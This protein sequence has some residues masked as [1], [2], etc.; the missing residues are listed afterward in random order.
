MCMLQD[1]LTAI[2]KSIYPHTPDVEQD[3][4]L[5]LTVFRSL[6]KLVQQEDAR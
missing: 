1:W 6:A 2:N 3:Y 5:S 4:C